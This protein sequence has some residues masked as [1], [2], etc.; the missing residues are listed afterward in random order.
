IATQ[1]GR[2]SVI[3]GFGERQHHLAPTV[4]E[5]REAVQKQDH[6]PAWLLEP[7]FQH[8][9]VQAVH[10]GDNARADAWRD[11]AVA[12]GRQCRKISSND[13]R[14]RRILGTYKSSGR[15]DRD[16]LPPRKFGDGTFFFAIELGLLG[17]KVLT[18]TT[19][20]SDCR[21]WRPRHR[22]QIRGSDY[23]PGK[24]IPTPLFLLSIGG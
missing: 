21:R 11:C 9:N 24:R 18:L 8:V 1:V 20:Q 12:V 16:E 2:D 3:T 6:P 13:G 17:H 10:I 19:G 5:F 23:Y 15:G 4:G 22:R 14:L 7:S